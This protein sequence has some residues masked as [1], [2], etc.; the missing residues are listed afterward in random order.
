MSLSKELEAEESV[1]YNQYSDIRP[2][3][4]AL[5]YH[6]NIRGELMDFALN[7]G[8][9]YLWD[10]YALID[11]TPHMVV[12][13]S[14]QCGLS[15]L[16]IIQSHLEAAERG[17]S[18]MYVLP[19][20]ELRNRF[21]NNR[22]YKLHKRVPHYQYMIFLAE[23][24]VHRTS[25]MH[26]GKGTLA[27]IGSN[28]E[29]EF[30]EIPVDSAFVD[31][32]DRCNLSNLLKLP[33]RLTASP[34]Q[35]EREISNPTIDNFGIDERYRES[36]EG[37]WNIR[38]ASCNT[39]FVPDFF[40]HVV[41]ETSV[42]VFVPRDKEADPDPLAE[43]ELRL[44][45]DCGSPIDRLGPGQWVHAY[46]SRQWKGFRVS[47]L[48]AQLSPKATLRS[49]YA[50]W[51]KAVGNELKIQIFHNSDLGL[52]RSSKGTR[53]T[54]G[55]LDECRQ[56]Y[57][58]PP[59]SVSRAQKRFMGV[60]VGSDLH[61]VMRERL[62]DGSNS[63]FRLIGL[64]TL[65][66]FQQLGQVIREWKPDCIVIDAMPE[67]HKVL[68]LKEDFS[69]VWS[70]RFLESATT[71]TK[72]VH[73]REI[74]MNRTAIMDYIRQ[75]IE[76]HNIINPLN[77]ES[78]EDGAYYNHMIAP[79]RILETNEQHPEKSKFVW[80]EGSKP[81]HFFLAEVYCRQA[82]MIM[83]DHNV[84]EFFDQ[85]A[86][87][88]TDYHNKRTVTESSLSDKDRQEIASLQNI[89]REAALVRIREQSSPKAVKPKVDDGLI[90]DTIEFTFKAQGYVDV[91]LTSLQSGEDV[92][93]V[94]R[95]LTALGYRKS[96]IEGQWIK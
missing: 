77:A 36:S 55:M 35:Y 95:W 47:K 71:L 76:L 54:R 18:V 82:G 86:G 48:I 75:D 60:D 66:G 89:T 2:L 3:F 61:V 78:L 49:L 83:P 45:H 53:I 12:E 91:D 23:T 67:I 73:K 30:I 51:L 19:K 59:T 25:L 81:D 88:L 65:P 31:E 27:Y 11:K 96:R 80:K 20:Y 21:V 46:P 93:D 50:K 28:V 4:W 17:M 84:F 68:E 87:A 5:K 41:R 64:W 72:N 42:N 9:N 52:P 62:K 26:F 57:Q 33:D 22:I 43:Q 24:K 1:W 37:E 6:R 8:S 34:Y 69:N 63:V 32:K 85:E 40:R 13:K 79:A 29:D 70:S 10:L 90:K 94:I 56:S 58:F 39:W 74:S 14:V 15:E 16:F 38:C 92:G 44:V 7:S